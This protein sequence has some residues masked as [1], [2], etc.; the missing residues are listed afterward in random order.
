MV[1]AGTGYPVWSGSWVGAKFPRLKTAVVSP[2][3]T[4]LKRPRYPWVLHL[5]TSYFLQAWLQDSIKFSISQIVSLLSYYSQSCG[6]WP[7]FIQRPNAKF[8]R[9]SFWEISPTSFQT[10]IVRFLYLFLILFMK[11]LC[12]KPLNY[13]WHHLINN[14]QSES[15]KDMSDFLRFRGDYILAGMIP[16]QFV[17]LVMWSSEYIYDFI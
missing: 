7:C 6:R 10:I 4:R 5:T 17:N 14:L 2:L 9:Y 1:G 13:R 12:F 15:L 3:Q 16:E 11:V 8:G